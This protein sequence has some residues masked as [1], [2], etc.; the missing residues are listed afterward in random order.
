MATYA[1]PIST[2]TG[3]TANAKVG[4]PI[5]VY[6]NNVQPLNNRKFSDKE[7]QTILGLFK[8]FYNN[9]SLKKGDNNSALKYLKKVLYFRKS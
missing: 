9:S 2:V 7:I 3:T 5:L 6:G 4:R 1:A 8:Y